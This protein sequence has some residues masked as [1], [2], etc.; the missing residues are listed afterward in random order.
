MKSLLENNDC[1]GNSLTG[2]RGVAAVLAT[3][4]LLLPACS[5]A[6]AAS[7]TSLEPSPSGGEERQEQP[8]DNAADD[9]AAQSDENSVR[10]MT[11]ELTAPEQEGAPA[12]TFAESPPAPAAP[13]A[14]PEQTETPEVAAPPL[15]T[16][17]APATP[18]ATMTTSGRQ[19]LDSCGNPFVT[20]GVEQVFGEQ[21]PQGNDWVGLA[22]EI[23]ASGVNAVRILA[24]TNTLGT[25]DVD[26]L[27]DVVADNG[28]V[29]YV[30]PYGNEAMQW[31][32]GQEVRAM[33]AKHEKYII[34][35][36]FGEP[37]FDDRDRFVR[38]STDA[39]RQVRSWGYRVPLT[40][41]A[42]QYGR[43]L[44]SILE[45][46]QQIISADPLGNTIMGWQAYWSSNGFYQETYGM[47]LTEAVQA[48]ANA[49]FP[50]QLG[51][52]RVTD[53]PLTA[54]A[55]FGTLLS[56]TEANDIGWLWWDW[57]NPYGDENNLTQDGSSSRLTPTGQT[58]VS[59]HA[60]SIR[61]TSRLACRPD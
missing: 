54:T 5:D 36:A 44:P 52:D 42:N 31:L 18:R 8:V 34:I 27:L 20:R 58:V 7:D 33:L 56:A 45:L 29:A 25:D 28:M 35:D 21:L 32:E 40:V 12:P 22:E 30:T 14:A 6:E 49:P 38:D 48:V 13:S 60:A 61:N 4:M 53:F 46:G 41:T 37:T 10:A 9:E 59:S 17:S 15:A 3:L 43:D 19:I 23:A 24:G 16:P 39:L 47:S 55:D 50:I 57:Y 11:S 26:A 51:L 2:A 1:I